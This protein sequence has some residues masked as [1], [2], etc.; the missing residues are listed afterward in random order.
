MLGLGLGIGA[1]QAAP[2]A[3][4]NLGGMA[5]AVIADTVAGVYG[6]GGRSVGF[7]GLFVECH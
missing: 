2:M 1:V 4:Y 3:R 5:P 6:L 7:D